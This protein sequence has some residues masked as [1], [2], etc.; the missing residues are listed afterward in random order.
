MLKGNDE[1]ENKEN[2]PL[3]WFLTSNQIKLKHSKCE[4]IDLEKGIK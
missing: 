2:I 1:F 3:C 4:T